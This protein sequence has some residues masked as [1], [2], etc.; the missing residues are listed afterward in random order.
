MIAVEPHA[1][2]SILPVRARPGAKVDAVLDEHGGA[3]RV[4]VTAAPEQGKAN[5]AI[6]AVLAE[7]LGCK[8]SQIALLSGPKARAKRFLVVG[9]SPEELRARIASKLHRTED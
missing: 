6:V 9:L 7:A 4:A 1:R 3:L 5:A 8:P 2:G